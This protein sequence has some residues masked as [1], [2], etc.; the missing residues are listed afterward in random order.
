MGIRGRC[1]ARSERYAK[2]TWARLVAKESH[3]VPFRIALLVPVVATELEVRLTRGSVRLQVVVKATASTIDG[4]LPAQHRTLAVFVLA[5][6]VA[7]Q[8]G[9]GSV[10]CG[11]HVA[12]ERQRVAFRAWC[13][14]RFNFP[15]AHHTRRVVECF[16]ARR[17]V[18]RKE[19]QVRSALR[20][21]RDEKEER[22]GL[23]RDVGAEGR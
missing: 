10:K 20:D 16:T 23:H 2:R 6:Y 3:A 7:A 22:G 21:G 12:F 17:A 9:Q 19:R 15:F 8:L 11:A 5:R 4:A 18:P 13:V 1:G 14:R